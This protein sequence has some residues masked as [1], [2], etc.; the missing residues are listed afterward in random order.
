MATLLLEAPGADPRAVRL[1]RPLT[2]I[3]SSDECDVHVPRA[4]LE[5]THAQIHRDGDR[6]VVVG[7]LRDMT[8]NGRR[9]KRAPLTH[10]A[11]IRIG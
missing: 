8:V 9:E 2:T 5:P 6:F 11:V 7:M 3:G 1:F 10:R 4:G